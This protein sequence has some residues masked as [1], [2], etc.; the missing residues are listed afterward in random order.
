MFTCLTPVTGYCK[1]RIENFSRNL[2]MKLLKP[3]LLLF[4]MIFSLP[5]NAAQMVDLQ[6][7]SEDDYLR[8][9]FSLDE[10]AKAQ[11][12]VNIEENLVFIRFD[13]TGIASLAKQS[14]LY[15][16][17]PHLES[18][19][20]LPL[21]QG[22]TVARVKA[23]HPFK[24]KTYEI[25]QPPRFVLELTDIRAGAH[26]R[27]PESARQ[28]VDYYRRGIEQMRSGNFNAALMSLRS[29]IRA[30]SRVAE[31]YYHAG[32]IRYKLS[33]LDKAMI[34]FKRAATS[35]T[36]GNEARLFLSWIYYKNGNYP[37]MHSAWRKFV[38][39]LPDRAA[40]LALAD[41]HPEIDYRILEAAVED[42]GGKKASLSGPGIEKTESWPLEIPQQA[43][44]RTAR[45]SAAFYFE[46]A[47]GLK[48]DGRLEQA[49]DDL[50]EAVRWDRNYS[51][52][53]FQL[54]VIYKSLGNSKLS[55]A[56]FEK[57]LGRQTETGRPSGEKIEVKATA[58]KRSY[59]AP[60]FSRESSP[61]EKYD[62]GN[63][64]LAANPSPSEPADPEEK[65][66]VSSA[67]RLQ[68]SGG[69]GTDGPAGSA[70][71]SL[72]GTARST[73]SKLISLAQ[74]GLL[75]KQLLLLTLIT[76]ILFVLTLLGEQIFVG[77]LFR[78]KAWLSGKTGQVVDVYRNPS[79]GDRADTR[80]EKNRPT[81]NRNKEQVAEVLASEL[82][83]IQQARNRSQADVSSSRLNGVGAME[84]RLNPAAAGGIYGEDIA[85]RIKEELSRTKKGSAQDSPAVKFGKGGNDV[86]A[87]LIQQLRSKDWS[88][89]D[90]AQEM[91]LSREEVKWA[92]SASPAGRSAGSGRPDEIH[93][94]RYG[95][96]RALLDREEGFQFLQTAE[97]MNRETDLE[98]Q[99]DI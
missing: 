30:G 88:I 69:S 16:E 20:F 2:T 75:R 1:D 35:S 4:W 7:F 11:V 48:A 25:S 45:D 97:N 50:E 47:M 99:I 32:V 10:P 52:A 85:H 54:G 76:G 38:G 64:L 95:Q 67:G 94:T 14:F 18:V 96:A 86:Q 43:A 24:V 81:I 59:Q 5:L 77:R 89:G 19:T 74:A 82:A 93:K 78:R 56:N 71:G 68:D 62:S 26:S 79:S 40:R 90:I 80:V 49:V 60:G 72:M 31:S 46:R 66:L 44:S 12:E 15:A 28:S 83:A 39:R 9:A 70:A 22:S 55:A 51:Q 63:T 87:R 61:N 3:G 6:V 36:Y 37:A 23:R 73:A 65:A 34:N 33:Q 57:S 92:L 27:T 21:G 41:K 98:L 58:A 8:V 91:N 17:N 84:L 53:Y 13:N 42:G 29:A